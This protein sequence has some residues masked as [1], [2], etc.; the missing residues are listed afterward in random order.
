[1]EV[2]EKHHGK[3]ATFLRC[4]FNASTKNKTRATYL[5]AAISR[6]KL[7]RVLIIHPTYHHFT[8]NGDSDSD[9]DLLLYGGGEGVNESLVNTVCEL[10][11][12]LMFSHHDLFVSTC[13]IPSHQYEQTD[14]GKQVT[15][16]RVPNLRFKTKWNDD[17]VSEYAQ[18]LSPLLPQIRE[19]WGGLQSNTNISLLIS[20]TYSAMNLMSKA[21]NKVNM[22][23]DKV[24]VKSYVAPAILFLRL[25]NILILCICRLFFYKKH[26]SDILKQNTRVWAN[27]SLLYIHLAWSL[28]CFVLLYVR[29]LCLYNLCLFPP[30]HLPGLTTPSV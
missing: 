24:K 5:S 7:S 18:L 13:T 4:D 6:L 12:P 25:Q 21:T 14:D 8:G 9:L 17:G 23:G 2:I 19:T 1:M 28:I 26:N 10:E 22:L 16:P 27:L 29:P 11:H 20:S 3:L 30:A 15:A